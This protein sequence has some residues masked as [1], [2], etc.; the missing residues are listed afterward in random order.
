MNVF[1]LSKLQWIMAFILLDAAICGL[2]IAEISLPWI[3]QDWIIENKTHTFKGAIGHPYSYSHINCSGDDSYVDCLENC[4]H[5]CDF[6]R[7]WLNAGMA[8][9]AL[10]SIKLMSTFSCLFV[11]IIKLCESWSKPEEINLMKNAV[12][13]CLATELHFISFIIWSVSV[14]L[15]FDDCSYHFP[16]SGIKPICGLGGPILAIFNL[17]F[18]LFVSVASLYIVNLIQIEEKQIFEER[19]REE[20]KWMEEWEKNCKERGNREEESDSEEYEK[21]EEDDEDDEY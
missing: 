19:E 18:F 2:S 16:Y 21:Y 8:Y 14:Q 4:D 3:K 11:L 10:W 13:I 15:R 9:A 17:F 1:G 5:D 6:L 20:R 12:A 7:I